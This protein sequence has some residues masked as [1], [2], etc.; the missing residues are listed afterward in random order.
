MVNFLG[1][2]SQ[3]WVW[4]S[5]LG[6]PENRFLRDFFRAICGWVGFAVKLSG[7]NLNSVWPE[8]SRMSNLIFLFL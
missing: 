7:L 2:K 4:L 1:Y 3:I 5:R 6:S 8:K